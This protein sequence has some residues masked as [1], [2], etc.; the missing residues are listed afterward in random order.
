MSNCEKY[1]DM[2]SAYAD[3]ELTENEKAE[4]EAHLETCSEC[5]SI[6]EIYSAI[7]S[8]MAIDTEEVPEGFSDGV[9]KKVAVYEKKAKTRR[10]NLRIAGRWIG[11][12]ACIAVIVAVFPQMPGLGCGASGAPMENAAADCGS[13]DTTVA[14]S[15]YFDRADEMVSEPTG[16]EP[17]SSVDMSFLDSDMMTDASD[18]GEAFPSD[19]AASESEN[20]KHEATVGMVVTVYGDKIPEELLN[21]DYEVTYYE[22]GD[23]EYLVPVSFAR[24]IISQFDNAEV[25]ELDTDIENMTARIIF[26]K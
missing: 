8:E 22:N 4:L 19:S 24:E 17:E 10:K 12:A 18:N 26:T 16:A 11:V 9:M 20:A 13:V 15:G 5:R 23:I 3:G 2:I 6:L 25:E 14:G 7:S 1:L 21:S